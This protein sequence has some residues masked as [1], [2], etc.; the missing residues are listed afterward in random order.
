LKR[1]GQILL[2]L[3]LLGYLFDPSLQ[4]IKKIT[5]HI[6]N[7]FYGV[8]EDPENDNDKSLDYTIPQQSTFDST[9]ILQEI[10]SVESDNQQ[11]QEIIPK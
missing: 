7:R 1:L 4:D 11:Q 6:S 3:I 9:A 2:V 5:S 10:D 8:P